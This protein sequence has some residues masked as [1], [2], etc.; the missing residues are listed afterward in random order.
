M[1][2]GGAAVVMP[3]GPETGAVLITGGGAG[4]GA[5]MAVHLARQGYAVHVAG[6]TAASLDAVVG[7]IRS[8]GGNAHAHVLDVREADAC[9]EVAAAVAEQAGR[10]GA[11]VNNAGVFRRGTATTVSRADW[12]YTLDINLTGALNVIQAAAAV[13]A[14]Q[15]VVA[16]A[17][18]HVVNINSGAG[19]RGYV[20]GV[21]Y[22]ASK[23]GLMGLSESFRREVEGS[24]IKVTDLVVAATVESGLS[25]RRGV[26]RLPAS[27]VGQAVAAVLALPGTAVITRVDLEQLPDPEGAAT[28]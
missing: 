15:D 18:G 13:M 2:P 27:V 21:A 26:R 22:A 17:R 5:A 11:V 14:G 3:A 12:D 10:L 28:L 7:T 23:F 19:I 8:A 9:R 1:E 24:Q 4:L 20:P 16:G 25:N 6:R